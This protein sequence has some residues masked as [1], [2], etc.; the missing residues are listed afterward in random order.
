MTPVAASIR[1]TRSFALLVNQS[2]PSGPAAIPPTP[3]GFWAG[4]LKVVTVPG[5][6]TRPIEP[7]PTT[8]ETVNHRLPSGPVVMS[9]GNGATGYTVTSPVAAWAGGAPLAM[10]QG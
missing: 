4:S 5:V 1:S 2:P 6:V 8:P 9:P 3:C 10:P 7:V